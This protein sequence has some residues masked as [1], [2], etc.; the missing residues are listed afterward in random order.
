MA[1]SSHMAVEGSPDYPPGVD[2]SQLNRSRFFELPL[3]QKLARAGVPS[4]YQVYW[5]GNPNR[6]AT[7]RLGLFG[8]RPPDP[9]NGK[10][11]NRYERRVQYIEPF[12]IELLKLLSARQGEGQTAVHSGGTIGG[13]EVLSLLAFQHLFPISVVL[14]S[15]INFLHAHGSIPL[16]NAMQASIANNEPDIGMYSLD[17]HTKPEKR[18]KERYLDRNFLT[19]LLATSLF[20]WNLEGIGSEHTIKVALASNRHVFIPSPTLADH[21]RQKLIG[22]DQVHLI[23]QPREMLA[24]LEDSA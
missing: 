12:F 1:R 9:Q 4:L 17:G 14:A 3:A 5:K 19:V 2:I 10:L 11:M 20:G 24:I 22:Y 7:M 21:M 16:Y 13:D 8:S 23:E 6:T 18:G 15:P